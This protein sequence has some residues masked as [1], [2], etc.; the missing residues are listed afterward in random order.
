MTTLPNKR[1]GIDPGSSGAI[2]V[3]EYDKP[4]EWMV[5]PLIKVG[6]NTRINGAALASF[7]APHRGAPVFLEL[8]HIMP[9]QGAGSAFT[10]GHAAGVVQGLVQGAGHPLTMVTPQKWKKSAGL[11]GT[12][13]DVA[14]ST[15]I[16][17]WPEWRALD[18]KGKGGA[19]AD[20]ALIARYGA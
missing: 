12:E 14:R 5:M 17:L 19:L 15:A 16:L 18:F 11:I 3:L 10:F 13:K 8:V 7:L 6:T 20:A 9:K 4:V 2:V 1:I